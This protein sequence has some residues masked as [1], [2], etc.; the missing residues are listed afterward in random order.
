MSKFFKDP[1]F[2]FLL[3]SIGLF[4][5]FYAAPREASPRINERSFNISVSAADADRLVQQFSATWQRN[6]SLDELQ[7]FVED[8]VREQ[9]LVREAKALG[10]DQSDTAINSRLVQKIRFITESL[11]QELTPDAATLQS[12]YDTEKERYRV[13]GNKSFEQVYLGDRVTQATVDETLEALISGTPPQELGVATMLPATVTNAIEHQVDG[14]FGSSFFAAL[15]DVEN[16]QWAGPIQSGF[17]FHLV[18]VFEG[19][20]SFIP[21][22]E[23]VREA[24]L[25][26]WRREKSGELTAAQYESFHAQYDV[27]TPTEEE[28]LRVLDK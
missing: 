4:A 27:T 8:N 10:L 6:P 26:D 7:K 28:L 5:L 13:P 9:I 24:V 3:L 12:Y 14:Q 23:D 18:K 19:S 11:V 2:H 25:V 22:L 17:G 21:P 16:D 20:P 1:A 15:Q